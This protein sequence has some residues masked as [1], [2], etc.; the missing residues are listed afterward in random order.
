MNE[1]N[2]FYSITLTFFEVSNI[3]LSRYWTKNGSNSV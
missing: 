1:Y 2:H 3:F